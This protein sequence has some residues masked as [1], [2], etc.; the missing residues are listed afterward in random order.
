MSSEPHPLAR[1]HH[2]GI[3]VDTNILLLLF[4]GSYDLSLVGRFRRLAAFT[5]T[6]YELLVSTLSGFPAVVTTPMI[7]TEVNSL[8]NLLESRHKYGYYTVFSLLAGRLQEEVPAT[9][10]IIATEFFKRFGYTDTAIA[11]AAR[12]RYLVLTDDF[13]LAGFLESQQIDARNF[14]HLRQEAGLL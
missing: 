4:V 7:L 2:T 12:Q 10:E 13:A 9:R 8:S 1:Y 3:I 11:L 6:D 14:H 5:A